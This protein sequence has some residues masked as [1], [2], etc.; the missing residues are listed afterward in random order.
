MVVLCNIYNNGGRKKIV[1]S[2]DKTVSSHW[3][4][5]KITILPSHELNKVVIFPNYYK[6]VKTYH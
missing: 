1:S 5:V 6:E 3:V 4:D 2:F